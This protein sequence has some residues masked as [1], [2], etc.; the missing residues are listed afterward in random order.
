MDKPRRKKVRNLEEIKENNESLDKYFGV[1][2]SIIM[3]S[4]KDI[5][6]ESYTCK[7]CGSNDVIEGKEK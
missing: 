4:K 2:P 6:I 1:T 3:E 7:E 5:E